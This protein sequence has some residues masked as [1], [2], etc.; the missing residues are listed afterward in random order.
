MS[1]TDTLLL[2]S[3]LL[4]LMLGS[5]AGLFAGMA[6]VLRPDWLLR[7]SKRANQWVATRHLEQSLERSVKL[8]P[9]FYRYRH[10]SGILTLAGAVYIL[11][12]FTAGLN[13]PATL[14]GLSMKSSIP[15]A[16]IGSLLD[17][18][19]L[20]CVLGAA[21]ALIISLFLLF[22]PSMLRGFEQ[23]SNRLLSL[24]HAL[25]PLEIK[26]SGVDEYVFH[27]ARLVGVLLLFGSLYTL[28]GLVT[29][30]GKN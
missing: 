7:V 16:L 27:N 8:D 17:A 10:M 6:L 22:R 24:R 12:F 21:F 20:S 3:L 4:F 13:K 11:Y 19:A 30:L 5:V 26:R 28:V 1:I 2:R 18:L 9:W 15:P 23:G 25:K 29:W 14:A